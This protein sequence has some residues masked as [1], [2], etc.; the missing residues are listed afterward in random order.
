MF[1]SKQFV[2][3]LPDMDYATLSLQL[4]NQAMR[5][6]F[7]EKNNFLIYPGDKVRVSS[8][9]H[10][11][12]DPHEEK[13]GLVRV[14]QKP[15]PHKDPTPFFRQFN[16][17]YIEG[18]ERPFISKIFYLDVL[19]RK[20]YTLELARSGKLIYRDDQIDVIDPNHE[21]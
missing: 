8:R 15:V 13:A 14:V 16:G 11:V 17:V 18:E 2:K 20:P 7:P 5:E 10:E 1:D 4:E 19:A 6:I 9:A 21:L 3:S 12:K